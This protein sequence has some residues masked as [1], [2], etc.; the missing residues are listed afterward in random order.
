MA[1]RV[2]R[3]KR[4]LPNATQSVQRG[5][6][7]QPL[8]ALERRP[9][10]ASASPRPM[11]CSGTRIGMFDKAAL[12]GNATRVCLEGCWDEAFLL[13][14][15]GPLGGFAAG[16]RKFLR[17][18]RASSSLRPWRSQRLSRFSRI[19]ASQG[20]MN[21]GKTKFGLVAAAAHWP[22]RRSR[23][24]YSFFRYTS[25]TTHRTWSASSSCLSIHSIILPPRE[26]SRASMCGVWP[27]T[28]SS[29]PIQFAHSRSVLV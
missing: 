17:R 15:R 13:P 6:G 11:K 12:P 22:P 29:S 1:L 4:S 25:E 2:G 28:S 9:I 3:C 20:S 5:D 14:G 7:N 18:V 16:S 26:I 10:A 27:S 23:L 8:V 24:E 19:G 21:T